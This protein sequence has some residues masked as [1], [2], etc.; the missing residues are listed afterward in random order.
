MRFINLPFEKFSHKRPD[1][2]TAALSTF[3]LPMNHL[4]DPFRNGWMWFNALRDE[5]GN[6]LRLFVDVFAEQQPTH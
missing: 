6:M 2:A 1:L 5:F 4:L 3:V